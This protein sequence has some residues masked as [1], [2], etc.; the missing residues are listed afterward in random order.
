MSHYRVGNRAT[1]EQSTRGVAETMTQS[2][3]SGSELQVAGVHGQP[4]LR[5]EFFLAVPQVLG[6]LTSKGIM[7]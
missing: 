2:G 5:S 7:I 6:V 3:E 1:A 4:W